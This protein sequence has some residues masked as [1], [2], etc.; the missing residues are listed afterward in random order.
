[1]TEEGCHMRTLRSVILIPPVFNILHI[2]EDKMI[3]EENYMYG[4][5]DPSKSLQNTR[6]RIIEMLLPHF[7]NDNVEGLFVLAERVEDHILR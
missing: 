1:M 3:E 4:L 6:E 5:M 7:G 2:K